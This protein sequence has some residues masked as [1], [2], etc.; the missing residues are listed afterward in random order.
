MRPR[1]AEIEA[2]Q[3]WDKS[4]ALAAGAELKN[5]TAMRT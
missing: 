4:R 1:D 2:L 5:K 3:E